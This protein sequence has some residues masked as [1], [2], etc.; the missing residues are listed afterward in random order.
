MKRQ[1]IESLTGYVRSQ[2]LHSAKANLISELCGGRNRSDKDCY[3]FI[4]L[5]G[6][7]LS[8]IVEDIL[9]NH[10]TFED[11]KKYVFC[12]AGCGIP[13][14][15]KILK[16]LGFKSFGVEYE[17]VFSKL[18]PYEVTHAN[19]L[20]YDFGKCDVVYSYNP[21]ENPKIMVKALDNVLSTM[22][23]GATLY[24]V[25]AGCYEF[26]FKKYGKVTH[27]KIEHNLEYSIFKVVKK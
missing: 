10:K 21:I 27:L 12:D 25:K 13:F 16:I 18:Y 14:I 22:K 7:R 15:P 24:F 23:S 4:P 6:F 20:E 5:E 26:D 2:E 3:P 19:I 11:R 8:I 1:E 17:K 9:K